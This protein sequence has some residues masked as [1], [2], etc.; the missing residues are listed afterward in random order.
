MTKQKAPKNEFRVI[1][2]DLFDDTDYLVGDYKT[3]AIA[4][5]IAGEHNMARE[6]QMSDVYY[7]YNDRGE[8]IGE[9]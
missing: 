6:G 2:V 5:N 3:C 9:D 7:V 1:G 8:Y 4:L